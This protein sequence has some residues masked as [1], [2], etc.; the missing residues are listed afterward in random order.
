MARTDHVI[1][2]EELMAYLDG[3]LS[4]DRAATAGAHLEH[5]RECQAIAADLQSVSRQMMAWQVEAGDGRRLEDLH[6][7]LE[8][9]EA[10]RNVE[11]TRRP[12]L[13]THRLRPWI[14]GLASAGACV[15]VLLTLATPNLRRYQLTRDVLQTDRGMSAMLVAPPGQAVRSEGRLP[16]SGEKTLI[17]RT[18]QLTL[19]TSEFD[20]VRDRIEATLK[21]HQGYIGSLGIAAPDGAARTLEATLRV[22]A[23]QLEAATT[24]MKTLGRVESESQSGEEVTQ[25][26]VD[27]EARLTNAKNTEQR[28]T[29]L[30]RQ[31]TGKLADVLAVEKE[32]DEVREKIERMEA[33]KKGLGNRVT[34]GTLTVKVNEEYKAQTQIVPS[35]FLRRFQNAAVEG[36]RSMIQGLVGVIEVLLSYGPSVLVWAGMLFFPVRIAWRRVRR[37]GQRPASGASI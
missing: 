6:A 8:A 14:V 20:R 4:P 13:T 30:L 5:C 26:Y 23:D 24:E 15:I 18:A 7:A 12:R 35:S 29:D 19:T 21:R 22:P 16:R 34:F 36:Y 10:E 28:L 27:L 2:P 11:R 9:R 33:E 1:E 37:G 32:I 3:E 31:R 17:V 25:Q